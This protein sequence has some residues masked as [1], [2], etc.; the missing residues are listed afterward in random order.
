M[1]YFPKISFALILTFSMTNIAQADD[2]TVFQSIEIE[3]AVLTPSK[4]G[5]TSTL[6]LFIR[7]ESAGNL[8][9]FG[10]ESPSH[11]RSTILVKIND[12]GYSEL[13]S[14]PLA[15]E[16]SLDMTSS[17]MIIQLAEIV[18]PLK[19][20]EKIPLKLILSNGELPFTAHVTE[21]KRPDAT[22]S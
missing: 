19:M 15:K 2:P 1:K 17:H 18:R 11:R 5:G 20:H 16:E 10:V 12:E 9:I 4:V 8:T 21:R 13:A 22:R 3:H 14:L 6:R 7:N